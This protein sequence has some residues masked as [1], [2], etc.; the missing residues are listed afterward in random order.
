MDTITNKEGLSRYSVL[1]EFTA[2]IVLTGA[3][4]KSIKKGAMSLRGSYCSIEGGRLLLKG[5]HISP[6]QQPNQ[7][8]YDPERDR[9]LLLKKHELMHLVG[10][11][12]EKGLT[13][14]PKNVYSKSGLIKVTLAL[15]VGIKQHD[16][17]Q[18]IKKREAERDIARMLKYR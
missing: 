11:L 3:E 17:R 13:M 15:A 8:G 7:R 5:A 9:H 16:K 4:V 18:L 10:K 1:E 6:Y 2:G 14:I 12:E